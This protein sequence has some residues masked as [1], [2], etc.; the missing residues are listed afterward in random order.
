MDSIRW[1][2]NGK[3]KGIYLALRFD[4]KYSEKGTKLE[5]E[6]KRKIQYVWSRVS[7]DAPLGE[8]TETDDNET[9]NIN[10]KRRKKSRERI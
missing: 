7:M 1:I 9:K 3:E 4:T 6:Y 10:S 2:L 8:A 5:G